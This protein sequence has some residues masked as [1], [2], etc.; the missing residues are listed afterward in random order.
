[1]YRCC[2]KGWV[3]IHLSFLQLLFF[4]FFRH[5]NL[6][7]FI[8]LGAQFNWFHFNIAGKLGTLFQTR[9]FTV[10]IERNLYFISYETGML[11]FCH[12]KHT[13]KWLSLVLHSYRECVL[14]ELQWQCGKK[15]KHT[16]THTENNDY[17]ASQPFAKLAIASLLMQSE[18]SNLFYGRFYFFIFFF[19]SNHFILFVTF[20]IYEKT[21]ALLFKIV[22][23]KLA[24]CFN[25]EFIKSCNVWLNKRVI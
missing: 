14:Q 12:V 21:L 7:Q 6:L 8:S 24:I 22:S 17:D 10:E 13:I 11:C 19:S 4:F 23:Q 16:Q 9:C 15:I 3:R 5:L 18:Y 1:M 25:F 2:S 20:Y